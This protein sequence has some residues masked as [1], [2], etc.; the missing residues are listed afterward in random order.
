MHEFQFQISKICQLGVLKI[1]AA[2]KT[3]FVPYMLT[4]N[5]IGILY[6]LFLRTPKF[7][8]WLVVLTILNNMKVNGKD[9][10]IYYGT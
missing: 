10:P 8:P 1:G 9:S 4:K 7:Y 6:P 5:V 3:P 2:L